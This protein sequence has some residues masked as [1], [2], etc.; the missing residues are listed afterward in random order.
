[1]HLRAFRLA[2]RSG[3][4]NGSK[5]N[6]HSSSLGRFTFFRANKANKPSRKRNEVNRRRQKYTL[7]KFQSPLENDSILR[8]RAGLA[9]KRQFTLERASIFPAEHF[10]SICRKRERERERERERDARVRDINW[11]FNGRDL[12]FARVSDQV[13][14]S[15]PA[16]A[17][18]RRSNF[19]VVKNEVTS[20]G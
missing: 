16:S 1:M 10:P 2:R 15:L 18:G 9:R 7:G 11:R 12:F 3:R 6:N 20:G 5:F 14:Y 13:N 17:R 8:S 19:A 4:A